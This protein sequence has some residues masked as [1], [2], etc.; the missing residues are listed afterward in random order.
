MVSALSASLALVTPQ[1]RILL[2]LGR[3]QGRRDKTLAELPV[4]I[5]LLHDQLLTDWDGLSL[6]RRKNRLHSRAQGIREG[7]PLREFQNMGWAGVT[8]L[9]RRKCQSHATA[10]AQIH[11]LLLGERRD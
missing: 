5:S 1:R 8:V 11:D 2:D 10:G 6:R 7:K 4:Q 9:L 3:S